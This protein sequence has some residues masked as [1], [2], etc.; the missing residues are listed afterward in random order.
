[1]AIDEMV[2]QTQLW[3]NGTYRNKYGYEQIEVNGKTGWPTIFALTRALQ[4]E[5]GIAEPSDNFGPTTRRLFKTLSIN[6]NPTDSNT[7]EEATSIQ[8]QIYILQG[9]LWCK[10]Y[11]PGGFTGYFGSNTRNAIIQLQTDAGLTTP[12]G[13]ADATIMRALLSMDT[14]KLLDY[15]SYNGDEKIRSIQQYLNNE[16]SS[17]P[18]FNDDLGLIPCNGIYERKTNQALVYS[19]QIEEGISEPTGYFGPATKERCPYLTYGSENQFVK[20]LQFSLYCNGKDF[21]PTGFT[22]YYGN[23]TQSAVLRFQ[24]FS[25]LSQSGNA[26]IQT[27]SSLLISTGDDTRIGTS[28]DCST[29]ITSETAKTIKSNGYTVV[30]RY[31]TGKYALSPSEL[32]IIINSG[33]NVFPI[34]ETGGFELQYFNKYQG[35]EDARI[36]TK[37]AK[38]LG[39]QENTIIYFGVDFD[40]LNDEVTTNIIPYFE[41]IN[42]EFSKIGRPYKI[43]IYAPR[44]VC[45]RIGNLGYSCSSFVCDMSTGFS[46]NLGYSLPKDWAFDQISTLGIGSS[47]SYIEIDNNISSGKYLGINTLNTPDGP[48]SFECL[49]LSGKEVNIPIFYPRY[50]YNFIEPALK[51]LKEYKDSKTGYYSNA[52][53]TWIIEQGTNS[54]TDISNLRNSAN[55]LGVNLLFVTSKKEIINY[56]NTGSTTGTLPRTLKIKEFTLFGH[57]YEGK[58]DFGIDYQIDIDDLS[59]INDNAFTNSTSVFYSCNTATNDTKSFAYKWKSVTGGVVHAVVNRTEYSYMTYRIGYT[60]EDKELI[61]KLRSNTGYIESGSFSYPCPADDDNAYWVMF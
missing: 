34:F 4:I 59:L 47:S 16:Y 21:D 44:N 18:F 54:V 27:W 36:A 48:T 45:T 51:K 15:D 40:V 56:I 30:G 23:G 61:D 31:L 13:E 33:L 41:G 52:K 1:M 25:C 3:L 50:K 11:N 43:G 32:S 12:N 14:F 22:G 42:N 26:G 39:F 29:S 55:K 46:G 49:V 17:N 37:A 10:G 19:L 9:A 28:C 53:I 2:Q 35:I 58:L 7:P 38:E 5:L 20:I 60:Q 6:S 24:E 8:N 57:G